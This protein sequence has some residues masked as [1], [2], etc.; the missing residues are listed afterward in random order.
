MHNLDQKH[1][2][3]LHF[4]LITVNIQTGWY[5]IMV[6]YDGFCKYLIY[7]EIKNIAQK[8]LTFYLLLTSYSNM[9]K[10]PEYTCI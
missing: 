9:S 3:E 8:P 1:F 7:I 10:R 4:V 5:T 2:I 6:F